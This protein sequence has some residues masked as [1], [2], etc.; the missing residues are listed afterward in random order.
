MGLYIRN[1]AISENSRA[2]PGFFAHLSPGSQGRQMG[3]GQT[4]AAGCDRGPPCPGHGL[5]A[6]RP[7]MRQPEQEGTFPL[8]S[9]LRAHDV[10]GFQGAPKADTRSSC[11]CLLLRFWFFPNSVQPWSFPKRLSPCAAGRSVMPRP[12][13]PKSKILGDIT[14]TSGCKSGGGQGAAIE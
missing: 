4:G 10:T 5:R 7:E 2:Y 12:A 9:G 6:G 14:G 11:P 8:S 1:P 3:L 13:L